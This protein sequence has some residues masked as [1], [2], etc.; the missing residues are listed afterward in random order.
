MSNPVK[1]ADQVVTLG[2]RARDADVVASLT[3][4]VVSSAASVEHVVAVSRKGIVLEY[5]SHVTDEPIGLRAAFDPVVAEPAEDD[6][7]RLACVNEVIAVASE[8]FGGVQA[9]DHEVCSRASQDQ[10]ETLSA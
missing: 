10:V 9:T 8:G 5:R 3:V 2:S 1:T 6:V 7:R 4:I